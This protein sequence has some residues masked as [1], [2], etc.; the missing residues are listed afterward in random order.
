MWNCTRAMRVGC[1]SFVPTSSSG[2]F[3]I[4]TPIGKKNVISV[5]KLFA[6]SKSVTVW[7][8]PYDDYDWSKEDAA[9]TKW[10]F[11]NRT[12]AFQ[13]AKHLLTPERVRQYEFIWWLNDDVVPQNIAR[14]P[15][16]AIYAN[17]VVRNAFHFICFGTR[18]SISL[19]SSHG[20]GPIE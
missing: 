12:S 8:V 17:L 3:L 13:I 20:Q 10:F 4:A 15:F 1:T 18:W 11:T 7:V 5:N 19:V 14:F 6:F 2:R 9:D 16:D